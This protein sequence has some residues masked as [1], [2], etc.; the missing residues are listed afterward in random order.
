MTQPVTICAGRWKGMRLVNQNPHCHPMSGRAKNALFNLLGERVV[1]ARVLDLYAGTGALGLEAASRGATTVMLVDRDRPNLVDNLTTALERV[2]A[3]G[4]PSLSYAPTTVQEFLTT[5]L[6][7]EPRP[8]F[9]LILADPPYAEFSAAAASLV[10]AA[11]LLA[12][13]GTLVVSQ[14]RDHAPL[15]L[16]G[17]EQESTHTYAG[18]G[19]VVYR[20]V[21]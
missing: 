8:E 15:V 16:P 9:D 14:P 18:A 19:L 11:Q 10:Q 2:D 5:A 7:R 4:E 12:P 21:E 6:G 1:G 3:D 13:G 17:L 20:R